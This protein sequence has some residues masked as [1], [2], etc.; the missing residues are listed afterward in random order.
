MAG[1]CAF[2]LT[3]DDLIV[4]KMRGYSGVALMDPAQFVIE[5]Q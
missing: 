5:V 3:T 4:K 2:F 1:G